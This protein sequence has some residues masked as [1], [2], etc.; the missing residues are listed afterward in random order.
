MQLQYKLSKTHSEMEGDAREKN[1]T[2]RIHIYG[3]SHF[4]EAQRSSL[5]RMGFWFHE[6][7]SGDEVR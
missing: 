3:E 4:T 1:S 7:R 5:L 2:S 6:L